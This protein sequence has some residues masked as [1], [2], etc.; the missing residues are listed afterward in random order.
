MHFV[1]ASQMFTFPHSSLLFFQETHFNYNEQ[2][3]INIQE[4]CFAFNA[5]NLVLFSMG[6][7]R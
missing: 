5:L 3:M 1:P 7:P 4:V 6:F 2:N